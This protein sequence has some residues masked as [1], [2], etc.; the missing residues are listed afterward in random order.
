MQFFWSSNKWGESNPLFYEQI[1]DSPF[2]TKEM[3]EDIMRFLK[4]HQYRTV[5]TNGYYKILAPG[6][7]TK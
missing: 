7:T 3:T 1:K 6:E 2:S 4:A 5:W